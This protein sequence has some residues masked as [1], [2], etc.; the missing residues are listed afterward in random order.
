[1]SQVRKRLLE[2]YSPEE[3]GVWK[4]SGEDPNC[5]SGGI[6][7][8]PDPDLGTVKGRYLDVV[9]YALSLS[10]FIGWGYGGNIKK[11]TNEGIKEINK[12]FTTDSLK[13][14]YERKARLQKELAENE[15][16]IRNLDIDYE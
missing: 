8:Q 9:E 14:L 3:E 4:I 1:M 10:N 6:H 5:D 15:E 13:I 2:Q 7:V 12:G 11:V 16:K